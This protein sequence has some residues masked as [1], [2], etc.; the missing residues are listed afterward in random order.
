M[1]LVLRQGLIAHNFCI[2]LRP[3]LKPL[4]LIVGDG[5]G[6][7][8]L[9]NLIR[10]FAILEGRNLKVLYSSG[11][12]HS[13]CFPSS[14]YNHPSKL[15]SQW[16]AIEL[17]CLAHPVTFACSSSHYLMQSWFSIPMCFGD[18]RMNHHQIRLNSLTKSTPPDLLNSIL[19]KEVWVWVP[20][21]LSVMTYIIETC[22][23]SSAAPRRSPSP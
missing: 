21:L 2:S 4:L 12:Y 16:H 14:S 18:F 11:T 19:L 3:L 10:I 7:E 6:N 8:C 22:K 5:R 13:M 9:L 15:I 20:S 23:G 17:K 1:F